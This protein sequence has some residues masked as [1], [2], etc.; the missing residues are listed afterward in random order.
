MRKEVERM[1]EEYRGEI[2]VMKEALQIA[3]M[4][5]VKVAAEAAAADES[6]T[7]SSGIGGVV[8]GGGGEEATRRSGRARLRPTMMDVEGDTFYDGAE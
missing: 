5:V 7:S 8:V 1:L 2:G 3:A 6:S 4:D